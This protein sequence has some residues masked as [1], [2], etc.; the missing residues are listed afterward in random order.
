MANSTVIIIDNTDSGFSSSG[1]VDSANTNGFNGFYQ[2]SQ[3]GSQGDYAIWDASDSIDWIA[4][5]WQVEMFWTSYSN[6][7]SNTLVTVGSGLET[8]FINQTING[9][10]W[11]DLGQFTFA[12][13]GS[14]VKID[15]SNSATGKYVI[16]DAV[17]FTFVS[18]STSVSVVSEPSILL[19][20]ALSLFGL[21]ITRLNKY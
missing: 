8:L 7:A 1:F 14:F 21:G 18:A 17:S 11:Q 6:R 4:G 13:S 10:I 20:M 5:I 12:E 3:P 16:A 9:G 19:V 2:I 15:D